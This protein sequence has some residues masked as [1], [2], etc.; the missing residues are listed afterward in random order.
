MSTCPTK[1]LHSI[2]LD[3]ELPEIYK[4]DYEAHLNTCVD[5]QKQLA[6]LKALKEMFSADS[7]AIS[8]DSLYLDESFERL[9]IK[10]SYSKTTENHS[11]QYGLFSK[12]RRV[13]SPNSYN[14]F[15]YAVPAMA[16]A[17]AFAFIIPIRGN[18]SKTN[19]TPETVHIAVNNTNA[20]TN[21]FNSVVVPGGKIS[22]DNRNAKVISG[23]IHN[24]V[25]SGPSAVSVNFS[26]VN[27]N[28]HSVNSM[29][30]SLNTNK[31]L[32]QDVDVFRPSFIF[33]DEGEKAI[34]IKIT[35]PGMSS[36]PVTTEIEL[37]L[38]VSSG[39]F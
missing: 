2:Y 12:R 10:M 33:N 14:V 29:G 11:R 23:N 13:Y 25:M 34:S 19:K 30:S 4:K 16:A 27:N 32:I 9:K 35:V 5:C 21:S 20:N 31:T 22:V 1:D 28:I 17:A 15:K 39:Q 18:L 6:K 7:Q 37:P 24:S 36:V 26:G 38:A 3:N 8:V